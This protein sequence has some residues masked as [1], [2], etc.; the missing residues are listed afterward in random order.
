MK[1]G[2]GSASLQGVGG[3]IV[4]ALA[5]VNAFGD[6]IEPDSGEVVAGVRDSREGMNLVGTSE[7]IRKGI[8]RHRTAFENTTLVVVATNVQ[9]TRAQATK[10]AQMAQVGLAR[11]LSPAHSP[12]DGDV[13]LAV[14]IGGLDGDLQLVGALAVQTTSLAILRAVREADGLGVIPAWRDLHESIS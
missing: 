14:S 6:V 7:E 12:F 2:L 9:L 4:G 3:V 10:M 11:S 8:P 13:I 1:G 5:V